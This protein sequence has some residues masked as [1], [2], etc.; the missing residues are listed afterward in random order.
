M[1]IS[2]GRT[3]RVPFKQPGTGVKPS[4]KDALKALALKHGGIVP[5]YRDGN[6]KFSCR[7][8]FDETVK[9]KLKEL[10]FDYYESVD[11]HNVPNEQIVDALESKGRFAKKQV[12]TIQNN[13]IA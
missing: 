9:L 12:K 2:F 3:Y 5:T 8:K 1:T 4:R 11:I 7:K 13:C 10:G 6:V